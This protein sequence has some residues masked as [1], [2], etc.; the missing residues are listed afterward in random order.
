MGAIRALLVNAKIL[1]AA[2]SDDIERL[3]G[4]HSR[5]EEV[6]GVF[7]EAFDERAVLAWS[8]MLQRAIVAVVKGNIEPWTWRMEIIWA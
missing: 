2:G 8:R 1:D 4:L 5:A 3:Q 7:A 6:C